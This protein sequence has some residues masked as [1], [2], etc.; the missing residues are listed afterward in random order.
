MAVTSVAAGTMTAYA[1]LGGTG[2]MPVVAGTSVTGLQAWFKAGTTTRTCQVNILWYTSAGTYL[3]ASA[4]TAVSNTTSGWTQ[5]TVAGVTA[6]ATAA[7]ALPEA[8]VNGTAAAG[9]THYVTD[10]NLWIS[11]ATPTQCNPIIFG[12]D[13]RIG[14]W[15][16][17][18]GA[19]NAA[20]TLGTGVTLFPPAVPAAVA[21][22]VPLVRQ[23]A[24]V[25]PATVGVTTARPAVTVT[26]SA[27]VTAGITYGTATVPVPVVRQDQTITAAVLT[28][29][30]VRPAVTV[31]G[32]A[33]VTA[34]TSTVT[35]TLPVPAVVVPVPT[36]DTLP[37]T[38]TVPA[39]TVTGDATVSPVPVTP[40]PVVL[41]A[42]V[43]VTGSATV[44]PLTVPA[45][46]TVP[47][48]LVEQDA[49]ATP[50]TLAMT[51]TVPVPLVRQDQT[52]TPAAVDVIAAIPV[53]AVTCGATAAPGTVTTTAGFPQ[54]I[55]RQDS[56]TTPGTFTAVTAVPA[57]AVT[58]GATA[59]PTLVTIPAGFPPALVVQQ[60]DPATPDTLT[61]TAAADVPAV[62]GGATAGPG[63]VPAT[64]T[65][66]VP[67]VIQDQT[68]SPA[69]PVAMTVFPPVDQDATTGPDLLTITAVFP[70]G[71]VPGS[72]N[73]FPAHV[74][75]GIEFPA[76]ILGPAGATTMPAL[77]PDIEQVLAGWLPE[78]LTAVYGTVA[79]VVA[80]TPYAME[81][82]APM[83]RLY[84]T[85]GA[86][87]QGIIDKPVISVD[88]YGA[89]RA[90]ASLL[91]RQVHNLLHYQ[92]QG[93]VTGG[94]VCGYVNTVAGP[95]WLPYADLQVRRYNATYEINIHAVPVPA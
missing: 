67:L 78:R 77:F 44:I 61:T 82:Q 54:A 30:T 63:T 95:R 43:T 86:D 59:A 42:A 36:P 35:V 68:T 65:I 33:T 14:L 83:V 90:S 40:A 57:P 1:A 70:P 73:L 51:A 26:G 19:L 75:A 4:G 10:V 48:P 87:I 45:T 69:P 60:N 17:L 94:A 71:T 81:L 89:D 34:A 18:Y 92:F 50:A 12:W 9:E 32:S 5:C 13:Y 66:P 79:R 28:V 25:A 80:E 41:V 27:T 21:V 29:T 88:S 64:A 47:V 85:T 31:T 39:P 6:P 49:T 56:T 38:T 72:L 84:R 55:V 24:T 37:V 93:A 62:T 8:Q 58:G 76:V 7:Y 53:P 15:E 74:T 22:P 3:S 46:A 11:G 91:A 16:T 20:P 23:D 52:I 2:G